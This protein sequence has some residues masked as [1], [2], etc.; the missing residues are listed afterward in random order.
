MKTSNDLNLQTV[1]DSFMYYVWVLRNDALIAGKNN[2]SL[3]V[4]ENLIQEFSLVSKPI[5][6]KSQMSFALSKRLLVWDAFVVIHCVVVAFKDG[7][8]AAA[9]MV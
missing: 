8:S 3:V 1:M 7:K 5:V 6:L 9:R 2:A 4:W